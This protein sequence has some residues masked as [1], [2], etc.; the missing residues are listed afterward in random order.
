MNPDFGYILATY[1]TYFGYFYP[2]ILSDLIQWSS[3]RYL[4]NYDENNSIAF[5]KIF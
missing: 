3:G 1:I 2:G 4:S 5:Q